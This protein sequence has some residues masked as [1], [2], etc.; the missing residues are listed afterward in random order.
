MEVIAQHERYLNQYATEQLHTL[1]GLHI[2]GP[3][4]ASLRS[5]ILSF[6]IDGVD[7]HQTAI[8]LDQASGVQVRSGQHCVHSWFADRGIFGSVRLSFYLYNTT[9]EIDRCVEGVKKVIAVHA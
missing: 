9:A 2:I 6:Y 8:L 4:D 5:G 3:V 1:P 7:I